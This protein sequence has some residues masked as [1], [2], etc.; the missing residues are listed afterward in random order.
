MLDGPKLNNAENYVYNNFKQE[1]NNLFSLSV[2]ADKVFSI[3]QPLQRLFAITLIIVVIIYGGFRVS[4]GTLTTGTLISFM[5][6]LLQLIGP[7]NNVADFYNNYMNAK[8]ST[9]KIF[10]ILNTKTE[11]NKLS[12]LDIHSVSKPFTLSLKNATFAYSETI[13]LKNI[14]MC[15]KSG[16]NIAIVG[17][18][19]SGKSTIINLI[20]RLY[21]L[22]EGMLFL[23]Q[24]DALEINLYDWRSLFGVVSQENTIFSG[25]ILDNLIFG[26]NYKPSEEKIE[27]ALKIAN[28]YTEIKHL[29]KGVYTLI[30]ERGM[31]LSGGQRQR[32]QIARAYLKD[33]DFLILDEATSSLDSNTEKGIIDNL[34]TIM[35]DKTIISIAH[36]LSTI[37]DADRIYFIENKVIKDFGT[38]F[39]LLKRVPEYRKYIKEQIIKVEEDI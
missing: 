11:K 17:A 38:H 36:R 21:P 19:G 3:T 2:K 6:F 9:E 16:E 20:T 27:K 26:L 30:G 34:K 24:K 5:I 14:N 8:G 28:L 18:T 35:K 15:F 32:L 22:K 23:N 13:I 12:N 10:S 31:K 29:S 1:V 7:I 4:Q 37:V 25:S 33:A 39:D